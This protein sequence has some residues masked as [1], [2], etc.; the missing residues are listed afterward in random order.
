MILGLAWPDMVWL[1]GA[2]FTAGLVRGFS[3]FGTAMIYLPVAGQV[4][5]PF[6]AITTLIVMDLVAPLPNAPRAWRDGDPG[7]VAR[8]GVGLVLALPLGIY[9][10]TLV[11]PDVFRYAVSITAFV[12]LGCLIGGFRYRG[13][14]TRPLIY[15]TGGLSG[16][17]GGISGIAGPPVILLYMASA[18]EARTV[19]ANTLLY[20]ILTDIVFLPILAI[21][22]RLEASSLLI[23][24]TMMVPG[25]LGNMAGAALFRPGYE[26]TYRTVAYGVILLSALS[27]LPV[28]D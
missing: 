10:L 21:F 27:G 5:S 7:D 12:L 14:M 15:G 20:L 26:R 6:G 13:P 9:T 18:S 24:V 17:L 23:G 28:W 1:M 8:L 22:G 2:A 19:R 11:S 16:F 3:G 4:L 25:V